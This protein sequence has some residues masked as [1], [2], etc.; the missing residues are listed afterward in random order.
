MNRENKRRSFDKHYYRHHPCDTG[1]IC[2][3]CGRQ[4]TPE[5]AGSA[6]RDHCPNC[7]CSKHLDNEPGDREADC[8]GVME[9]IAVWVR[10]NGEWAV[11]HRCKVCGTI[12]SNRIAA[13]DNPMKLMSIA[14][15]PISQPPFPI[16]R[17][18]EMTAH[19]GGAGE[20]P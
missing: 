4:V 13:D 6:H 8:G 2:S 11:V 20:I 3:V 9:P 16:E 1:F 5:G 15:R 14:L 17:I 18:R 7:L 10:K 19:M 12:H